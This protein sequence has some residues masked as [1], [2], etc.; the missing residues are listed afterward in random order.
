MDSLITILIILAAIISFINKFFKSQQEEQRKSPQR[1]SPDTE[2]PDWQ[3]PWS[4]EEDEFPLPDETEIEQQV[5]PVVEKIE[6]E[7]YVKEKLSGKGKLGQTIE[8][9]EI[10]VP[11]ETIIKPVR[12]ES[13]VKALD[14]NLKSPD[15]LKKGIVLSEILG[16]CKARKK[17]SRKS[18]L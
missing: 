15:E 10:D 7:L 3:F 18:L 5:K 13:R 1:K 8:K 12:K 17:M 14:I 16:Q 9:R 2:P 11:S 6:H 4:E